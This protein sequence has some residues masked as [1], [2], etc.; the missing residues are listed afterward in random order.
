[1]GRWR[2]GI[3]LGAVVL[4]AIAGGL[5]YLA[6]GDFPAPTKPVEKV[7]PNDRFPR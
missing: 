3:I 7:L 5:L 6:F 1:M 2:L 4:L